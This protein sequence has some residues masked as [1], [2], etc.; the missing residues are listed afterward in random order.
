MVLQVIVLKI[1]SFAHHYQQEEVEPSKNG[2]K[3]LYI[4]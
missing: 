2:I 1:V 4:R 3:H